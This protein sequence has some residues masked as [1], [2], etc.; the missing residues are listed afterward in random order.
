M[1]IVAANTQL[2]CGSFGTCLIE[3]DASIIGPTYSSGTIHFTATG[4]SGTTGFANVTVPRIATSNI[5]RTQVLVNGAILPGNSV[6]I[7]GNGVDYFIFFNFTFHSP[8]N[9]DIQL[10]QL[11][12]SGNFF[13]A[14][15]F[16]IYAGLAGISIAT[17]GVVAFLVVRRKKTP[18]S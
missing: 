2:A 17:I 3:S 15:S 1:V 18:D 9:V 7:T 12:R 13:G 8:A 5:S 10:S 14:S 4:P 16:L 11:A 6:T